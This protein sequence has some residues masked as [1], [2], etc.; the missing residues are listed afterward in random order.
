MAAVTLSRCPAWPSPAP[1]L[2]LRLHQLQSHQS[3]GRLPPNSR[4]ADSYSAN[5]ARREKTRKRFLL[6]LQSRSHLHHLRH[7]LQQ[8]WLS[9]THPQCY[10]IP[11]AHLHHRRHPKRWPVKYNIHCKSYQ[12]PVDPLPP[13][14]GPDRQPSLDPLCGLESVPLLYS[15]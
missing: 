13:P 12:E 10:P 15:R 3:T 9:S 2:E 6:R 1:W 8:L 11:P 7:P 5:N 4:E 14:S